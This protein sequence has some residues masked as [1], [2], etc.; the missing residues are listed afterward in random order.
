MVRT[1]D[2]FFQQ[3]WRWA[4]GVPEEEIGAP[5]P[6]PDLDELRS[7]EFN[8]DFVRLMQNRMVMGAF[9][10]G[11][12]GPNKAD[13]DLLGGIQKKLAS[14]ADTGNTEALVDVANYALLEFTFPHHQ[15]AHFRA[16]DDH[17]HCPRKS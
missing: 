1:L 11:R 9:R 2:W 17:A 6:L 13:Y 15:Q 16:A 12:F 14:Y 8:H 5:A 10:Y 3:A 4:A 7:T